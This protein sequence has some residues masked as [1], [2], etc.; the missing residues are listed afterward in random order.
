MVGNGNEET[1]LSDVT[2]NASWA[3]FGFAERDIYLESGW[4]ALVQCISEGAG[5]RKRCFGVR[6]VLSDLI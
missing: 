3:I 4:G 5:G 6:F 1:H 2:S